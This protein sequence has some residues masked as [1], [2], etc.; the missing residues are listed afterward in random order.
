MDYSATWKAL[1]E[2]IVDLRKK[3][4]VIPA[5]IISD[6]KSAKTLIN[7]LEAD[8]SH[9]DT[10]QKV[11]QYL[12]TVESYLISEGEKIFGTE[13][14]RERLKRLDDAS[15]IVL[16]E[17]EEE[18]KFVTGVPREHRW[19]RVRPSTELPI[20]KLK[21]LAEESKLSCNVQNDG[22]LVVHGKAEHLKEFVEKMA[23]E[24]GLKSGE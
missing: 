8:S 22:F 24:Y 5:R 3:G 21:V 13:Y 10:A 18:A 14:V 4:M 7:V 1:E 6:L 9:V 11:E 23:K 2:M 20:E 19:I 16:R 12:L 17:K 15:R